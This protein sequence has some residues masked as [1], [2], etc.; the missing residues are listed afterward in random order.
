MRRLISLILL[1]CAAHGASALDLIEAHRAALEHDADFAAEVSAADAGREYAVQSRAALRPRLNISGQ[2]ANVDTSTR[3]S[4][5]LSSLLSNDT[6]GNVYGYSVSLSRPLYRPDLKADARN[7]AAQAEIAALT[8]RSAQQDLI[9]RVAQAYFG[10]LLAQDSLAFATAQK[11]AVA[12]QLA[13]AKERFDSGRARVTDVAEAQANFD[14]LAAAQIAAESDLE[15]SR[16]R[17]FE[18]TGRN[19]DPEPIAS[20]RSAPPQD[21]QEWRD[22]ARAES[23]EVRVRALQLDMADAQVERTRLA[24]R[25]SL[26]MVAKY[27]DSRQNGELQSL[28]YPDQSRTLQVGV[29]F[30]M[31]V[32]AGGALQ[33][34]YRQAL[35]QRNQARQE[36]EGTRRAV[37]VDVR[38][39]CTQ[40]ASGALR[41]AALEQG[42]VS[43]Q[44]S[45]EAGELGR[46]VGNRTN[47][48][49]LNLQQQVYDAKRD[50]ADARYGYWLT[51][52]K[53]AA[54]AG[55]L[56]ENHLAALSRS[57]P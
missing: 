23:I 40:V 30:S 39:A 34:K 36:L 14:S 3:T 25:I 21:A 51:Q 10:V 54:L 33:S 38:E 44:T 15:V 55:E 46:E 29:Q 57:A 35:A 42:L 4:G 7:L 31:P 27:E 24:G 43:A 19:E 22:R 48:D 53:L 52:L 45:L 41:V 12:E 2:A 18:L 1:T 20:G 37:D 28:A 5:T 13:A 26:D 32:F 8:F 9:L 49:V 56:S 50:L 17:F 47:L 6:D 16:A 11:A